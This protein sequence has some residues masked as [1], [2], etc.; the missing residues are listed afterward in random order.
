MDTTK[1]ALMDL[2]LQLQRAIR[3]REGMARAVA[4][5]QVC[6]SLFYSPIKPIFPHPYL[7]VHILHGS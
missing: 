3:E 7:S 5:A 4:E 1:K 2:A 6:D